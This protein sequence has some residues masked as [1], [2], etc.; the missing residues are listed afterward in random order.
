MIGLQSGVL[1]FGL[2][3]EAARPRVGC[4]VQVMREEF[5]LGFEEVG[6]QSQE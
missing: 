4:V 6:F 3:A 2:V 5:G 1:V